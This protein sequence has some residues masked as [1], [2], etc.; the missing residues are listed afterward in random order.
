MVIAEFVRADEPLHDSTICM[1][2]TCLW[3]CRLFSSCAFALGPRDATMVVV[4][5]GQLEPY[6]H[7]V[8]GPHLHYQA[9]A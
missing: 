7:A 5:P 8:F 3:T 6:T 4:A 9:A 2:D 1:N